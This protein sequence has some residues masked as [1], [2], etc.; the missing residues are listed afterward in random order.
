MNA[1]LQI[2]T[3][4]LL[5]PLQP[6]PTRPM[7][8]FSRATVGGR[9]SLS[10]DGPM[11]IE[12]DSGLDIQVHAGCLWVPD[13]AKQCSVGVAA[14]ECFEI[15]QSGELLAMGRRGTQVELLWPAHAVPTGAPRTMAF[16]AAGARLLA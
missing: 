3:T 2:P 5:P 13:P 16:L 12:A 15:R 4:N 8:A 11:R 7:F 9:F 1:V 6:W 10:E 14:G